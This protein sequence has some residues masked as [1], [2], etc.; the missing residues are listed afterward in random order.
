MQT[1]NQLFQK[2]Y[3]SRSKVY[4]EKNELEVSALNPTSHAK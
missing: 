4:S 3:R 2:K 1:D